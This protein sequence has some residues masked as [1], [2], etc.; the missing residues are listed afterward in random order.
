[1]ASSLKQSLRDTN[2]IKGALLEGRKLVLETDVVHIEV[3][4]TSN[5]VAIMTK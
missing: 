4:F 1:M 5:N 2:E 3:C